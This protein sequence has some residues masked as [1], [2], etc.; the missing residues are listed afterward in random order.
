[1]LNPERP[2]LIL[3]PMEGVTDAAMRALQGEIGAFTFAVSEF[4]RVSQDVPGRRMF[5]RHI[6][7][8]QCG[9]VTPTGLPVGV[10]I[11]GGDAA[12]MA[13]A[14]RVAWR[15]GAKAIDIN[16]GC[17]A[18]TV[19]KHDGGATLLKYPTR[20]REIVAAIRAAVPIETPV[21]AKLRLGW[22]TLDAID[23]NA[24]MAAEGGASW[25]TI[26][27]RT[28]VAGYAPPAY[29]KP[30]GRVRAALRIP[31]VANGDI[32]SLEDF[33][34]CR[35]ETGCI[36][37]MLG[38]AAL[39]VPGLAREIAK[40]LGIPAERPSPVSL[41]PVDWSL[42]L[43]RLLHWFRHYDA[44]APRHNTMRMKQWLN[45]ARLHGGFT[46]F[47]T[48]K[49]IQDGDE[50]LGELNRYCAMRDLGILTAEARAAL[51]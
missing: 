31:V 6:P 38:R 20:I 22:D 50:L 4:L 30:I 40:D 13:A 7:E 1:M 43:G 3:A 19:N 49:R 32:F 36:H 2:A 48:M 39:A 17:P 35:E 25:I 34:R 18:P 10:Q 51:M 28:R 8:L 26:H 44:F 9:A 15:I 27:G 42:L 47:E 41:D 23:E 21:S 45:L 5:L 14:A 12:N 11:L 29:W 46:H 24:A 37:F 33:R 16:F